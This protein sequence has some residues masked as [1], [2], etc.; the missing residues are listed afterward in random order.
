MLVDICVILI[1]SLQTLTG[2]SE[3]RLL[4]VLDLD[5]CCMLPSTYIETN[6]GRYSLHISLT[7]SGQMFGAN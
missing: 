2:E 1:I 6:E 4:A 3:I 7:Y 5:R